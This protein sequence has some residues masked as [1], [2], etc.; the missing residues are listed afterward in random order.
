MLTDLIAELKGKSCPLTAQ[1][2]NRPCLTAYR[3]N[4]FANDS[5]IGLAYSYSVRVVYHYISSLKSPCYNRWN[6]VVPSLLH[7]SRPKYTNPGPRFLGYGSQSVYYL[8]LY[9][10]IGIADQVEDQ[11]IAPSFNSATVDYAITCPFQ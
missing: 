9:E 1:C 10:I 2:T 6:I 3:Y 4:V 7:R 11:H 5:A 8:I